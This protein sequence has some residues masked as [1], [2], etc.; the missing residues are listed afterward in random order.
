MIDESPLPA[1]WRVLA[2]PT[3]WDFDSELRIRHVTI[4]Y[5][6]YPDDFFMV[7]QTSEMMATSEP[8]AIFVNFKASTADGVRLVKVHGMG[9][10]V[11][12]LGEIVQHFPPLAWTERAKAEIVKFLQLPGMRE[13][14][15]TAA[16]PR[17]EGERSAD[18]TAE[19][20]VQRRRKITPEHLEEV[21][22]I[23]N[24]AQSED[25]PPTRAVQNHFGVSH[26]TAAKWVGSARRIGLLPPVE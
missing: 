15:A 23:Y 13:Q 2:I 9:E 21:A 7:I 20:G 16:V 11:P 25:E 17:P 10:W 3:D 24:H 18:Q 22:K 8:T 5:V 12:Y 4:D 14:L 19:V 26:S 1:D 6:T